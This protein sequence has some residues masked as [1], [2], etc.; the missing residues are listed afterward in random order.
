[1]QKEHGSYRLR[2]DILSPQNKKV[3]SPGK[4]REMK[5]YNL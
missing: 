2:I 5:A 1:M 3:K 4:L